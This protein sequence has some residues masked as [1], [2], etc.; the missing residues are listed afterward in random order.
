MAY[1]LMKSEPGVYGIDHLRREGTTLWD[2]IRNYQARNF[3]RSM[4][5]GDLAF[6]YH[7]NTKPPGI[8]GLME[9][10]ETHLVDPSQFDPASKYFD[11]AASPETPRW[12]CVRLRYRTTYPRM[13]SL[14]ALRQAF[15][16]E[17][18]GVVKRGNRLSILPVPEATARRLE[19]LLAA[20][21]GET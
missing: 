9:V 2:G 12:D 10:I 19:T 17:A 4:V 8:V 11:A 15:T 1:W 6:F 5:P 14:D 21:P 13:L 7:S 3:M 18:L 16:P 20:G